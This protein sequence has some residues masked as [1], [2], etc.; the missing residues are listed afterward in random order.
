MVLGLGIG[1]IGTLFIL[2]L[3]LWL[4]P[5]FLQKTYAVGP[6]G[7]TFTDIAKGIAD[8][9][10]LPAMGIIE[11][12]QALGELEFKP[13]IM[14]TVGVEILTPWYRP[15][16]E[17]EAPSCMAGYG[18]R[19]GVSGCGVGYTGYMLKEGTWCCKPNEPASTQSPTPAAPN[20][21]S[22]STAY[23]ATQPVVAS[24]EIQVE[25]V[26]GTTIPVRATPPGFNPGTYSTVGGQLV[27]NL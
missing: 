27:Y 15:P 26:P 2:L 1:T 14:P 13:T 19:S 17:E 18:A 7:E 25:T 20:E 6:P 8:M 3:A 9:F 21:P 22:P 11:P 24:A 12:I 23:A 10:R 4:L 16:G 5:Q